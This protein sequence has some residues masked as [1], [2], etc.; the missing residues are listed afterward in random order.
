MYSVWHNY[1][2]F[3]VILLVANSSIIQYNIIW[4]CQTEYMYGLFY[5]Y[6]IPAHA[7]YKS[8]SLSVPP[9]IIDSYSTVPWVM[10]EAVTV[11]DG[12]L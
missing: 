1:M 8:N 2:I 3:Y 9:G 10:W 12:I 5:S 4:L 7:S 6:T 11:V